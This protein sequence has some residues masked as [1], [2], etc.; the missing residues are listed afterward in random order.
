MKVWK[1]TMSGGR[2]ALIIFSFTK[3]KKNNA[4]ND[5]ENE[6]ELECLKRN[7]YPRHYHYVA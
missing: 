2:I 7:L 5:I 4:N 1:E 6:G 3:T